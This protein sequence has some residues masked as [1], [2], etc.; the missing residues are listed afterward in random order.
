LPNIYSNCPP[1]RRGGGRAVSLFSGLGLVP[2]CRA[3]RVT[4]GAVSWGYTTV[5]NIVFLLLVEALLAL[6]FCSGGATVLKV[7]VGSPDVHE[8]ARGGVASSRP[9]SR[10]DQHRPAA[11][12]AAGR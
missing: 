4:A 6:L 3:A 12:R 10:G 5:V 9:R 8:H 1:I 2:A 7:M 11:W